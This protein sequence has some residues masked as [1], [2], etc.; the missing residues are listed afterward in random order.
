MIKERIVEKLEITLQV[1]FLL[2]C[3]VLPL[4]TAGMQIF[5]GLVIGMSIMLSIVK[6]HSPINYHPFLIFIA[7]YVLTDLIS[8]FNADNWKQSLDAVFSNDWIIIAV[9]F[10]ISLPITPLWRKRSFKALMITASLVGLF[11]IVQF[12]VGINSQLF[13]ILKTN[14]NI[15]LPDCSADFNIFILLETSEKLR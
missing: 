8:A 10:L 5:L 7:V 14:V 4:S 3:I 1:L 12:F 15:L 9:P 6:R 2:W 13:N 11:G